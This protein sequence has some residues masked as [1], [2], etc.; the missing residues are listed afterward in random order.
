MDPWTKVENWSSQP[1][2]GTTIHYQTRWWLT[3]L[4]RQAS[5][6][7]HSLNR[8]HARCW[9]L[10]FFPFRQE[11]QKFRF[12]GKYSA[13][14]VKSSQVKASLFRQG[15]PISHRLVSKG[16][17]RK[18]RTTWFAPLEISWKRGT[19]D[20]DRLKSSAFTRN[21]PVGRIENTFTF[22]LWTEISE[23]LD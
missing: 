6:H 12:R 19:F 23:I 13:P 5:K 22:F 18:I 9:K 3:H 2:R 17:L 1:K 14:Q 11:F 20:F 7:S 4:Q 15:S 10:G 21:F 8:L 16:A